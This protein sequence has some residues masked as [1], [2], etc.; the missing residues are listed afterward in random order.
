MRFIRFIVSLLFILLFFSGIVP[1]L[2]AQEPS[3]GGEELSEFYR[4]RVLSVEDFKPDDEF[5]TLKQ[6]AEVQLTSG[7]FEGEEVFISNTYAEGDPY[8]N[9]YLEEGMEI[10]LVASTDGGELKEIYLHDVARDTG[11]LYLL[12]LFVIL[13]LLVGR[14]QGLKTIVTLVFTGLVLVKIMLPLLLQGYEPIP[15]A[16]LSAIGIIIFSLLVIGGFNAKSFSA[17]IGTVCGVAAAGVIA[18][19]IGEISYLTGFSDEEAQMLYFMEESINIRGLLFAGIIIGSLGAV[20]DVGMSVASAAAE[21]KQAN[22]RISTLELTRGAFNVGRDI[23]GT[24]ANTLV[25]AYVGGAIPLLLLFMGY[26]MHWLKIVN[27][28]LIA[29]E[30][31][32]GMAGSIGLII[33]IPVTAVVSAFMMGKE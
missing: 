7:P 29:T 26:E 12:G 31:V 27:L 23:M 5:A 28:D 18:L 2:N 3:P 24:M 10:L 8:L 9:I 19:W 30:F 20:T 15:V 13:L 4:G 17:I 11:L 6:E 1:P 32:R 14:K 16:T 21:I 33:A 22:K 25:L